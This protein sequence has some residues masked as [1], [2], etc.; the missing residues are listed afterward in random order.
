MHILRGNK[1]KSNFKMGFEEKENFAVDLC[2]IV[3][4]CYNDFIKHDAYE[5]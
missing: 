2:T 4:Y 5:T 1:V 3:S